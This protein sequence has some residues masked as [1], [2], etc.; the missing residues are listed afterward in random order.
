MPV[1]TRP[2]T[3]LDGSESTKDVL[4]AFDAVCLAKCIAALPGGAFIVCI[5]LSVLLDFDQSTAT[6]CKNVCPGY[7]LILTFIFILLL[8]LLLFFFLC[9]R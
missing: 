6:H 2:R 1:A 3:G 4:L 9:P 5:L 7:F 8:L